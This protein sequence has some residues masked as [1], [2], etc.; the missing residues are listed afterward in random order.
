MEFVLL[1]L[2]VMES[3]KSLLPYNWESRNG[4]M[5][6]TYVELDKDSDEF[7]Q[8][9]K[10]FILKHP[11]CKRIQKMDRIENKHAYMYAM[12]EKE[13]MIFHHK[14]NPVVC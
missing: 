8:I 7:K 5:A 12:I 3:L 9:E 13:K 1:L 2:F 14:I 6:T 11:K 4:T 10:D